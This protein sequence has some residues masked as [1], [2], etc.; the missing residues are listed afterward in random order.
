MDKA[1][2]YQIRIPSNQ[3]NNINMGGLDLNMR[4]LVFVGALTFV[5]SC[6]FPYVII[7]SRVFI[8]RGRS[9]KIVSL[10]LV[11]T[12][13]INLDRCDYV[14]AQLEKGQNNLSSLKDYFATDYMLGTIL[15]VYCL[16]FINT[17]YL[18]KLDVSKNNN[19]LLNKKNM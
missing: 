9:I 4:L 16:L 2:C 19:I 13:M 8:R 10:P 6:P 11:Y 12:C 7:R 15:F 18:S 5:C 14:V 17:F 1:T 3:V